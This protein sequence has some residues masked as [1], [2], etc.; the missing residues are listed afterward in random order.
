VWGREESEEEGETPKARSAE[1]REEDE[2]ERDDDG[3]KRSDFVPADVRIPLDL[4][5]SGGRRP[6]GH[7][8]PPLPRGTGGCRGPRGRG[9]D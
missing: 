9:F 7:P 8:S 4:I 5:K 6:A 1:R 2:R 3:R